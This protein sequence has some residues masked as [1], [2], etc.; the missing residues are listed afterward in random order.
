MSTMTT[1][2]LQWV[3][4]Y[5]K[6]TKPP[7]QFYTVNPS[8]LSTF[9]TKSGTIP[10]RENS[11]PLPPPL[12]RSDVDAEIRRKA[13]GLREEF[14]EIVRG[15]DKPPSAWYDLHNYFDAVDLWLEGAVFLYYV[16]NH[17]ANENIAL[18]HD[19]EETK[20]AEIRQWAK[21][22]V[23][24]NLRRIM[25]FPPGH[26]LISIFDECE[27][28]S[29]H[30]L[31][32]RQLGQLRTALNVYRK[33][34]EHLRVRF[35]EERMQALA[36]LRQQM[37]LPDP[38]FPQHHPVL[39]GLPMVPTGMPMMPQSPPMSGGAYSIPVE[40]SR[41]NQMMMS[42][43]YARYRS[44]TILT[45]SQCNRCHPRNKSFLSIHL[46]M[47]LTTSLCPTE[48]KLFPLVRHQARGSSGKRPIQVGYQGREVGPSRTAAIAVEEASA[49]LGIKIVQTIMVTIIEFLI[50]TLLEGDPCTM[51][52]KS[53]APT[54]Q[55]MSVIR[56]ASHYHLISIPRLEP[57]V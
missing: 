33:E 53:E 50:T 23:E 24:G 32:Q 8:R 18:N 40:E 49:M 47:S 2:S 38:S 43:I 45:K 1:D 11:Y 21:L 28:D 26:D 30:S 13:T 51:S 19:L 25:S 10:K 22:W 54:T 9:S 20:V 44:L 36:P 52:H 16:I 27:R 7:K 15:I 57:I 3:D 12:A 37:Y 41:R 35:E 34:Y 5:I 39:H 17:I 46:N 31:E 42:K 29:I 48:D 4:T 55:F 56:T 6:S 14:P